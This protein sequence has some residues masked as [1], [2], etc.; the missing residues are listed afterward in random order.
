MKAFGATPREASTSAGGGFPAGAHVLASPAAM[1]PRCACRGTTTCGRAAACRRRPEP[2]PGKARATM[3][4]PFVNFVCAER[5]AGGRREA[6]AAQERIRVVDAV[7]DY[8]DPD[9][10]AVPARGRMEDVGADHGGAAVQREVVR[11]AR[12]TRARLDSVPDRP[13]ASRDHAA[14]SQLRRSAEGDVLPL[15]G[16]RLDL[17]DALLAEPGHDPAH[18]R[19]GADAP[20][21][22]PTL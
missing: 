21:M 17:F 6:C 10:L 5:E 18:E 8:A 22:T 1:P 11:E 7:V 4:F 16:L 2:G 14:R 20:A 13:A 9:S 3:I 19:L 15:G 12:P